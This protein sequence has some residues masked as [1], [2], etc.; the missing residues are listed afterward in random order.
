M[1]VYSAVCQLPSGRME[2]QFVADDE[3]A[4]RAKLVKDWG[5]GTTVETIRDCYPSKGA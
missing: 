1:P 5:E 2:I 4:A 3:E